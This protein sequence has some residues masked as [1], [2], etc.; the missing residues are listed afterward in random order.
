MKGLRFAA[1]VLIVAAILALYRALP[2]N[3]TTVALTLLLAILGV[4]ARWGLGEATVASLV[5]VLGFN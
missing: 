4:S 5:A 3:S 1:S 2:V